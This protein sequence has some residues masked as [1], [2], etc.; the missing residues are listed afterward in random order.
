MD[1]RIESLLG[2]INEVRSYIPTFYRGYN[3]Y[4]MLIDNGHSGVIK[5]VRDGVI[6]YEY[7]TAPSKMF[8]HPWGTFYEGLYNRAL[9]WA[10]ATHLYH[11]GRS[12]EILVPGSLDISLRARC[13]RNNDSVLHSPYS[14]FHSMHGNAAG[15]EAASGVEVYTSPGETSSDPIAKVCYEKLSQLGLKMRPGYGEGNPGPDKES[16][17]YVLVNTQGPA[18][19]SETGFYT[20]S[21]EALKMYNLNF[22]DQV[23][24]LFL[25][26][27]I[28]VESKKLLR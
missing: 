20:N 10:T 3:R 15:V 12:Y 16:R 7:P 11:A 6:T 8:V 1:N 17:F 24:Q 26:M 28:E 14:Y 18:I 9:A 27:D 2:Y 21:E 19:L 13:N 22:I 4:A 25:E 5:T 23:A